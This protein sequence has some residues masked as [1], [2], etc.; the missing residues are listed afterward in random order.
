MQRG[1]KKTKGKGKTILLVLVWQTYKIEP[2]KD[3]VGTYKIYM[4]INLITQKMLGIINL[5]RS[6]E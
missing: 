4:T 3:Y 5:F 1:E 6:I 2:D